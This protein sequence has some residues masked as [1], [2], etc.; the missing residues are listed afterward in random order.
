M[1]RIV[2]LTLVCSGLMGCMSDAPDAPTVKTISWGEAVTL[3]AECKVA[4]AYQS[5]SS[6]VWLMLKGGTDVLTKAPG[7][8]LI[9][10]E[11]GNHPE[12]GDVPIILE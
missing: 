11:I 7:L 3:V 10:E 4:E 2:F 5:H 1:S 8:D 12:C 9:I 6:D